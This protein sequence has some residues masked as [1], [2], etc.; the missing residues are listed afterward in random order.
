MEKRHKDQ[1]DM[2]RAYH[3]L[4]QW[5]VPFRLVWNDADAI[6][7]SI[8]GDEAES[9]EARGRPHRTDTTSDAESTERRASQTRWADAAHET[10][11]IRED[12]S[13]SLGPKNVPLCHALRTR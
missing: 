7:S 2:A 3:T 9:P 1:R 12:A 8:D 10:F 5:K 6:A 4:L 13:E 11:N